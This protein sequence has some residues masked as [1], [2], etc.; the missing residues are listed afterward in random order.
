MSRS[1]EG[2]SK[3]AN[4]NNCATAG[5]AVERRAGT[6]VIKAEFKRQDRGWWRPEVETVKAA[7]YCGVGARRVFNRC[8]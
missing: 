7:S 6:R 8:E 3:Q 5:Q 2:R 1:L 4:G